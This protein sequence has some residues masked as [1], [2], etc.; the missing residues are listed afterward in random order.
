MTVHRSFLQY[1]TRNPP[2]NTTSQTPQN[3]K[4]ERS[5]KNVTSYLGFK[6]ATAHYKADFKNQVVIFDRDNKD[7][8]LRRLSF[9]KQIHFVCMIS[10]FQ[11]HYNYSKNSYKCFFCSLYIQLNS[12]EKISVKALR[13]IQKGVQKFYL[14][15]SHSRG[16]NSQKTQ[17][18]ICK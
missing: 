14:R 16:Q 6:K 8:R 12:L 11:N 3:K 18:V 13:N 9:S 17:Q 5:I 7:F 1:H 15:L 10:V 2:R 4:D